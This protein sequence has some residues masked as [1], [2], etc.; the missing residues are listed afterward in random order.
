MQPAARGGQAR[1]SATAARVNDVLAVPV[2]A[3]L[4]LI[5]ELN[6]GGPTIMVVTHDRAIAARMP[7][8]L[9]GLDGRVTGDTGRRPYG[10]EG[11]ES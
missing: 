2:S 3:L 4:D 9:D 1:R 11:V 7:R 10:I 8:R 6:A 5:G